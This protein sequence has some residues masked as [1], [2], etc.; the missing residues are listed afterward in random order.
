[1]LSCV[2]ARHQGDGPH[3]SADNRDGLSNTRIITRVL[4]ALGWGMLAAASLVIGAFLGLARKW[5]PGTIGAVLGFGA[6]ALISSVAF[7]LAEEGIEIGGLVAVAVGFGV[8]GINGFAAGA[9]PSY[10]STR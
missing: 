7:E 4:A 3:L 8:A 5:K 9:L 1:V 10:W 2:G 6:G